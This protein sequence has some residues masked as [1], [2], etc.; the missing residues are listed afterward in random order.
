MARIYYFTLLFITLLIHR[1]S[2]IKNK[3]KELNGVLNDYD[4]QASGMKQQIAELSAALC[5]R[6]EEVITSILSS[7]INSMI[8][9]VYNCYWTKI[10]RGPRPHPLP[11]CIFSVLI[12][13]KCVVPA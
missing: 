10:I 4:K 1:N 6:E 12:F 9:A 3:L 2:C 13:S 11:L 8:E 7:S 5:A